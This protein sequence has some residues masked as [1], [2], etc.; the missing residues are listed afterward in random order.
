MQRDRLAGEDR[1]PPPHRRA[2]AGQFR[3]TE[4]EP[5]R[6]PD[7]DR[8]DRG[9]YLQNELHFAQARAAAR[10][11]VEQ[12]RQRNF[13]LCFVGAGSYAFVHRTFLEYFCAADF[14]HQFNVAKTLDIDGLIALFD[15]QCRDDE[16]REVLRLICGQIDE[17]FVGRIVER[18]ATRTDL[19]K[20]DGATGLPE[21]PLAIGCL[22]EVR[23]ASRLEAAGGNLLTAVVRCFLNGKQPPEAFV[24][25]IVAA[26]REMGTRWPGKTVFE[27]AGQH[28]ESSE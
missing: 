26:G 25:D 4:G 7:A 5:D 11:V 21:L 19:E 16:W 27:F 1:H 22:S 17:Q 9:P 6:R 10:A 18:L 12:L 23:S 24:L 14:V 28:P 3:R 15:Q 13:I 2:H 8:L 20:W